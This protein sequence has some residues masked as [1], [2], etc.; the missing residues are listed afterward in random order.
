MLASASLDKPDVAP[1]PHPRLS[2]TPAR[3]MPEYI[4]GQGV[5]KHGQHTI[6]VL[7]ELGLNTSEI[8]QLASEGALGDE[9]QGNVRGHSLGSKL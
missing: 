8:E 2:R 6:E 4:P 9:L 1:A 3:A 5:L 7:A